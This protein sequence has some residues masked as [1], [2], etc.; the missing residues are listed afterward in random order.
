M[1]AELL[2]IFTLYTITTC[3]GNLK[4]VFL[5]QQAIKPVYLTT[6]LDAV[7]F[8]YAFKLIVG[9]TG[10]GFVLAFALGRIFGVF[11]ADKLEKKLAI[12]LLEVNVYKHPEPGKILAD[13]LRHVGYSVTTTIGYGFEGKHRLILTVILPRKQF[14][15]LK[16]IVEQDGTANMSVKTITKTYGKVGSQTM[17]AGNN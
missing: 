5:S 10:Y 13:K 9:S 3:L 14:S 2:I 1:F 17:I 4:S 8:T 15:E 16:D 11:L 7:I 6:F 12:G